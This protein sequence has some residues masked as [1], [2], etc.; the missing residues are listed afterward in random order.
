[1]AK[2]G[3]LIYAH[4]PGA[5]RPLYRAY[6][7]LTDRAERRLLASTLRSGMTV[8]D[9]GANIGAYSAFFAELVKPEGI[10]YSFEPESRNFSFLEDLSDRSRC[11]RPINAAVGEHSG[12]LTL[13]LSKDLNV[14]HHTYDDGEGRAATKVQ[15]VRLDD[16]FAPDTKIDLIKLDIQGFE[17]QALRGAHRILSENKAIKLLFE[18]WPYGLKR[19][20]T[21]PSALLRYLEELGFQLTVV[22]KGGRDDVR[23]L[24]EGVD[25]YMNIFAFR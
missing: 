3:N 8:L 7:A 23:N 17:M 18:Y 16:F 24:G 2:L 11:I 21:D 20:G 6:K 12:V 10:V 1:M 25:D 13:Y 5:Y 19:A 9:V 14:D 22:N 15:V 4:C